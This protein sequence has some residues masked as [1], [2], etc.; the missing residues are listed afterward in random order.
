[1]SCHLV[2][3]HLHKSFADV[4]A[5]KDVS[6]Q[7]KRGELVTLL[8]PSGCG[9]TTTLHMIAGFITPDSGE[10]VLN[11]KDITLLAP[12]KRKT[13]MVFQEY[14]LFP[15][16]N[17]FENIAYGLK[18]HPKDR[19]TIRSKVEHILNLL[20]LPQA[21]GRFPNQLSGGQQQRIALARALVLD[22]EILLLDEPLSNLDAKLRIKVR[23]E[24]KE[25]R[26]QFDITTIFVTHDQEEALSISDKIAV[27]HKGVVEQFGEPAEI[28]YRPKNEFVA[29]FIG[30]SN[31]LPANIVS[32]SE[33]GGKTEVQFEWRGQHFNVLTSQQDLR[34][35]QQRKML[36]RP[37]A[38]DI[39]SAETENADMKLISGFVKRS[40]FLGTITRYW[41]HIDGQEIIVDDSKMNDHGLLSGQVFFSFKDRNIHFI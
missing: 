13:P 34:K 15:H 7:I 16:L 24:I 14:A 9:K 40:S 8:G 35:G 25:L 17:V 30:E 29:S 19:K 10:I 6:L 33:Q 4:Q 36:L 38:F 11:D 18:I 22:P 31:F 41:I 2:L 28:Y 5:V 21:G 39:C 32:C 12:H 26:R 3:K 23:Y 37:E 20:G 27:M 1:M